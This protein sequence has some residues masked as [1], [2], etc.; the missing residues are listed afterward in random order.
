MAAPVRHEESKVPLCWEGR[1]ESLRS[2]KANDVC[3]GENLLFVW[4]TAD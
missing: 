3:E 2:S 4:A 1:S